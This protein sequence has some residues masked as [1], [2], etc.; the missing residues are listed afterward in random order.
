M[1][2]EIT[3][4]IETDKMKN[5]VMDYAKKNKEFDTALNELKKTYETEDVSDEVLADISGQLL[6]NQDFI[7]NLS[8]K[9]PNIFKKMY[10]KIISI[11][12]KI[13][14]NSK[15]NLF[16]KDLKNKWESAYRTQYNNLNK[17]EKYLT[18]GK[19]GAKKLSKESNAREYKN[20]YKNEK[21]AKNIHKESQQ[22]LEDTNIKSKQITGWFKTKYGD[23]GTLI[24]D[25]DAKLTKVL[26]PNKAYKLG[27]IFKHDL[28][29]KAYPELKNLKIKT[30]DFGENVYAY[31]AYNPK[32]LSKGIYLNNFWVK[33]Q[34]NYKGTLLHEINHY[35]QYKEHYNK[36]SRGAQI[37]EKDRNSNLGEI[38]SHES[39]I[40][41][42]FTQ[43]ELNDIILPE[44]AKNNPNYKNIKQE[45]L[46]Y[47]DRNF[48]S[49]LKKERGIYDH[50]N[51]EYTKNMES[52]KKKQ[53]LPKITEKGENNT[54]KYDSELD[55]S[56]FSMQ[57]NKSNAQTDEEIIRKSI[58]ESIEDVGENGR[59]DYEEENNDIL[60]DQIYSNAER[61]LG[62]ELTD[63]DYE[64]INE[65][66][67]DFVKDGYYVADSFTN[68][69]QEL[70][71][72]KANLNEFI[73]NHDYIREKENNIK[74]GIDELESFNDIEKA[75][76]DLQKIDGFINELSQITEINNIDTSRKSISTYITLDKNTL[77]NQKVI[78]LL[79]KYGKSP[80]NNQ[81]I[82]DYDIEEI[83]NE[84]EYNDEEKF[85]IRISDHSSG[86]SFNINTQAFIDYDEGNIFIPIYELKS[87]GSEMKYSKENQTWQEHLEKNYKATGKRTNMA[88]LRKTNSSNAN[89]S[90]NTNKAIAPIRKDMKPYLEMGEIVK[91]DN[92]P[93]YVPKIPIAEPELKNHN[94]NSA[95]ASTT[96]LI[97][98]LKTN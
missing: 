6:G 28:L 76:P 20:L 70:E 66:L 62:R 88:D 79:K 23:W 97:I 31:G 38:I 29:Y 55:N 3:H 68:K 39:K 41:S 14:G 32:A 46:K 77:E 36:H 22:N 24:S 35:I 63:E 1:T 98:L 44:L 34:A 33:N 75:I 74:Y 86:G 8:T 13:T 72:L 11:A 25:K 51:N 45:L 57:E 96:S 61:N 58:N 89:T 83:K 27:D 53:T 82:T 17:E 73:S 18:I 48:R 16:I 37:R 54:L 71:S 65:K 2:H 81:N 87:K 93:N 50:E 85:K 59:F 26:E 42:E 12:N 19:K 21:E 30:V 9:K 91:K 94:N 7:L 90:N 10:D 69:G 49:K 78:D 64:T 52:Q 47:N 56:S 95:N 5:L 40:Y 92:D 67:G 15:E 84:L 4:A 60:W 80:N 43:Q